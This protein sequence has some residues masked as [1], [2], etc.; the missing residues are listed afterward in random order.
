MPTR[1]KVL[2]RVA[3]DGYIHDYTPIDEHRVIASFSGPCSS[4]QSSLK[5]FDLGQMQA[6]DLLSV[7]LGLSRGNVR[8][9]RNQRG[10]YWLFSRLP[11]PRGIVIPVHAA[12]PN[13]AV[14]RWLPDLQLYVDLASFVVSPNFAG[15]VRNGARFSNASWPQKLRFVDALDCRGQGAVWYA[16]VVL[17]GIGAGAKPIEDLVV[18][19]RAEVAACVLSTPGGNYTTTPLSSAAR[20]C[21]GLACTI[22]SPT[23]NGGTRNS[24]RSS[25]TLA[26]T[27]APMRARGMFSAR[28]ARLWT[29]WP[30]APS[31]MVGYLVRSVG[32]APITLIGIALSLLSS[33]WATWTDSYRAMLGVVALCGVG[34]SFVINSAYSYIVADVTERFQQPLQIW[35]QFVMSFAAATGAVV[36]G[37]TYSFGGWPW[38]GALCTAANV[39]A[40]LVFL[41]PIPSA[42]CGE[43]SA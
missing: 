33:A 20:W 43:L 26:L 41:L 14:P 16:A 28:N 18:K 8:R 37:T 38:L 6:R 19:L 34:W 39:I 13:E 4:Q 30:H 36:A 35:Y 2:E 3:S 25:R 21:I 22:A 40:A 29:H 5:L 11:V 23:G 31:L 24:R 27:F 42:A 9:K 12:L 15:S 7:D 10:D 32:Y 17:H 1:P